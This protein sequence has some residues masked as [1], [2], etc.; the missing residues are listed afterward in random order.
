MN[1]RILLIDDDKVETG[2]LCRL[3]ARSGFEV[4]VSNS[5]PQSVQLVREYDPGIVILDL[6]MPDMSGWEVCKE[7]RRF[8]YVHIVIFSAVSDSTSVAKALFAGAD[9]YLA[10]PTPI[11]VLAEYLNS[12]VNTTSGKKITLMSESVL[13]QNF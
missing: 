10:K 2:L 1:K 5:S 3:L 8:S 6:M 12:I 11:T 4:L 9:Y 13:L 7:I